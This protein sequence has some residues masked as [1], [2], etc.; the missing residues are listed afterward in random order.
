[1]DLQLHG[2]TAFIS[3]STKGIG[4]AI[5]V[6]LAKEGARVIINGRSGTEAVVKSLSSAG[7]VLGIEGDLADPQDTQRICEEIDKIGPLDILI[8][9]MGIFEPKPFAEIRD[10]DWQKFFDVNIMSTVR[11]SR[12]FFDD[13]LQR[14]FGRI[15]HIASEAGLR[16]LESMVHYSMTKGAQVVIGRG[17][18]NLTKGC[19]NNITVNSVLP[20]P[21]RTEGV[22]TWLK[23]SAKVQGKSEDEFVAAFFAET[24]PNSLIQRF[25]QPEEIASVVT[26][27]AS[28]LSSVIN[29]AAIRAE[30]G[31]IKSIV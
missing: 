2:K 21:T 27:L 19:G 7:D 17:M 6:A 31:L 13:M 24:E 9:N 23:D 4:K 25:I 10:E 5:A 1:M 12:Y 15:I 3:G 16:G 20:G 26:F 28:P 8:N 29:G 22:D 30:G 18:A 14:D 11:L